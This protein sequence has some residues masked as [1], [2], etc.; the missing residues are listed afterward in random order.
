MATTLDFT[1]TIDK[2]DAAEFIPQV[3]SDD[4]IAGYKKN[5]VLGNLASKIN[6]K[7]KKGS[8]INIPVPVRGAASAK[9]ANNVVTLVTTTA[10]G[11]DVTIN[12]HYEYSFLVED[13]AA[14]QA[15]S[16][17]RRFYTDDAGYAL[18]TQVDT[19]LRDLAATW[20][21]G[22]A[23]SGA[24]IGSDGSSAATWTGTGNGAAL[25]DA[26]IRQLIQTFDDS[27]VP[28]ADRY[29]VI[30]PVEKRRLLGLSRFT[31]QAFTGEMGKGSSIRNGLVGDMYGVEVFVSSNI[32]TVESLNSIPYRMCLFFHKSAIVLAEQVGVRVQSQYKQE[33]LGTLVTADR[34]YGVQTVR[35]EACRAISVPST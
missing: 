31:E 5:L 26:G 13:I 33:A 35:S 24:V 34:L 22:T 21:S 15:M 8:V 25:T 32:A 7:G 10:T 30:P 12:K 16:S 6:H 23:Y 9:A 11:L 1:N 29:L 3:W 18:A 17:L 14:V 19:D 20:N 27:D 2:T 4:V 28:G